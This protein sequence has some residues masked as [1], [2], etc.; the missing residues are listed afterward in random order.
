[1]PRKESNSIVVTGENRSLWPADSVCISEPI[2]K[3]FVENNCYMQINNPTAYVFQLINYEGYF[4]FRPYNVRINL[5]FTDVLMSNAR[6]FIDSLLSLNDLEIF[7]TLKVLG[8]FHH[9]SIL[10]FLI[11]FKERSLELWINIFLETWDKCFISIN[12][13]LSIF[14]GQ[15]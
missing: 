7:D 8:K 9:P 6:T 1:M 12:K 5:H 10:K 3:Y 4:Y 2:K 15:I 14:Q 11:C 13:K